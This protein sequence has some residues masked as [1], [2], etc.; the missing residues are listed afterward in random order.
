[1]GRPI[2]FL[3]NADSSFSRA[4]VAANERPI[5]KIADAD[6]E[7]NDAKRGSGPDVAVRLDAGNQSESGK[8]AERSAN[9][10]KAGA[11]GTRRLV[12][13]RLHRNIDSAGNRRKPLFAAQFP[14]PVIGVERAE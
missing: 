13:F 5:E 14:D 8:V 12:Q 10:Q 9:Q 7:G 1:M 6:R 4:G 11:A 3:S 2:R